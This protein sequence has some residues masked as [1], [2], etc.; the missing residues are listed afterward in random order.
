MPDSL[1]IM[2]RWGAIA[3]WHGLRLVADVCHSLGTEYDGKKVG[4]L[5][6]CTV[7]SFHPVK[8]ITTGEGGMV[9]TDN[10]DLAACMSRF[11]NHGISTDHL[12]REAIGT[13]QYEMVKL[14]YNYRI[15][16]FQCALGLSQFLQIPIFLERRRQIASL[17][18]D[19]FSVSK[20]I[21]SIIVRPEMSAGHLY[22]VCL[23]GGVSRSLSDFRQNN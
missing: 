22:A 1:V 10:P 7:F 23:Q 3:A 4:A 19:A 6:D 12:Q 21:R 13:W 2:R 14:G 16:D 15:T 5:T 9:V 18:N 20:T 11:R 17:Y 8:H